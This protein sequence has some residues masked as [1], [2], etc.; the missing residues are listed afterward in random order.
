M[1]EVKKY[2]KKKSITFYDYEK[3]YDKGHHDCV[4]CVYGWKDLPKEVIELIYQL[5]G[6]RKTRLVIWN[7]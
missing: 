1:E 4:L 5:M 6:K 2:R 7:K 3:A